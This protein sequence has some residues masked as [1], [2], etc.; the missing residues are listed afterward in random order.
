MG[1]LDQKVTDRFAIYNGDSMEIGLN[2]FNRAGE[3][4]VLTVVRRRDG[5]DYDHAYVSLN[6]AQQRALRAALF[7]IGTN[8]TGKL[9]TRR[10]D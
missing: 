8:L 1:F 4:V 10:K 6:P 2:M 3:N 9:R 5:D 7:G